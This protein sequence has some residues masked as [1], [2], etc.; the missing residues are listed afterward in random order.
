MAFVGNL[1]W[2]MLGGGLISG[3]FWLLMGLIY[4]VTI[5]GIPLGVAAFRVARFAFFPF[6]KQLV[7]AELVGETAVKGS[8]VVNVLWVILGGFWLAL[9][10]AILGL[11]CCITIIGI[12]FG[13]AHFKLSQVSFAPLGKRIVPSD[14]AIAARVHHA[15]EE[16]ASRLGQSGTVKRP[17]AAESM[18]RPELDTDRAWPTP[19]VTDA[20]RGYEGPKPEPPRPEYESMPPSEPSPRSQQ[21]QLSASSEPNYRTSVGGERVAEEKGATSVHAVLNWMPMLIGYG[22]WFA[23]LV[24]FRE[25]VLSMPVVQQLGAAILPFTTDLYPHGLLWTQFVDAGFFTILVFSVLALGGRLRNSISTAFPTLFRLGNM[26]Y[27]ASSAAAVV[28]AYSAYAGF[29]LPPLRAQR[30]EWA[31]KLVLLVILGGIGAT[32]LYEAVKLVVELTARKE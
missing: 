24:V 10:H 1:L 7:R 8:G 14:V 19:R 15:K 12:P 23:L 18:S 22:V 4:S 31:Y 11:Y 5:I 9:N 17:A 6:G 16:L 13:L 20:A 29:V 3:L 26:V 30:V 27:L 2:F 32:S 28:I 21:P 25:I